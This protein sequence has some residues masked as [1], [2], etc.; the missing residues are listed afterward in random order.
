MFVR[1]IIEMRYGDT[2]CNFFMARKLD[3]PITFR[4]DATRCM[5]NMSA[6]AESGAKVNS[7]KIEGFTESEA[8]LS[9]LVFDKIDIFLYQTKK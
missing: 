7:S 9:A 4:E 8:D 6:E 1:K 5:R 3:V 2:D